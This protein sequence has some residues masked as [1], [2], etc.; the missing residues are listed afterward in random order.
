MQLSMW[1]L[2]CKGQRYAGLVSHLAPITLHGLF[3]SS[4]SLKC[5]WCETIR[6]MTFCIVLGCLCSYC[7]FPAPQVVSLVL[8]VQ[9]MKLIKHGSSNLTWGSEWAQYCRY[10]LPD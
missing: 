5:Q 3:N 1:L 2:L 8:S 10:T 7:L 4:L 6:S 9:Q